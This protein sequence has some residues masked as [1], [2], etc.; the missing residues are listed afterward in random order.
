MNHHL[1][2]KLRERLAADIAVPDWHRFIADKSVVHD[3]VEPGLDRVMRDYALEFWLTRE[4]EPAGSTWSPDEIAHGLDRT[5]RVILQGDQPLPPGLVDR[6]AALPEVEHVH[7][8]DVVAAPIPTVSAQA[9]MLGPSP[10]DMIYLP[11]AKALTRGHPEIRVAVLDTGADLSH[12]ELRGRIVQHAN[13]VDLQGLDTRD[14]IGHF[15]GADDDVTDEVGHGTHVSGIIGARGLQMDEGVAPECSLVAVRVLATMV[16][17]GRRYGAGIVDNINRGIKYAVDTARADVINMSLGIKHEGGALPHADIIRYALSRNVTVVAAS[18]NDGSPERYYP[19]ALPG[20]CAVGAVTA[21]GA[22]TTFTSY[23]A[24]ITCVAPGTNIYSSFADHG[25]AVASGT[26]QASP[27]VAG[28][29]ALMRS[30][31]REQGAQISNADIADLLARTSDRA[32][33]QLRNERGGYGLINLAD[34]FKSLA[35]SM[36]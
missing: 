18:G 5:Y 34:G 11:Y 19:G 26:S 6:I 23:G 22:V 29:V 2:V 15:G 4:Y 10:G 16:R 33:G 21:A 30:Y 24:P 3:H 20:V 28:S 27:F 8:I 25:Y 9:S 35:H 7:G 1:V 17:D 32:D 13:F 36:N 14:F 12:P 31:A